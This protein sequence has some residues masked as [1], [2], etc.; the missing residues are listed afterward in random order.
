MMSTMM[1]VTTASMAVT[2]MN[3]ATKREV[4][5][6]A[7]ITIQDIMRTTMA[8]RVT[9]RKDITIMTTRV[10]TVPAVMRNTM[11]TM[12][13]M[14]RRVAMM[15]TKNGVS[16]VDTVDMAKLSPVLPPNGLVVDYMLFVLCLSWG[17]NRHK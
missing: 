1:K 5:T 3:M 15:T 12:N 14:A 17:T 16:A 11:G 8:R 13:T 10:T 7:A 4:I 6:R 2:T 9:M